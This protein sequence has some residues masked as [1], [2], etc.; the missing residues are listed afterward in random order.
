[1][2]HVFLIKAVC[3]PGWIHMFGR[4]SFARKQPICCDVSDVATTTGTNLGDRVT[5][6]GFCWFGIADFPAFCSCGEKNVLSRSAFL[7]PKSGDDKNNVTK[8]S[9]PLVSQRRLRV[10]LMEG[11]KWHLWRCF[12][13]MSASGRRNVQHTHTHTHAEAWVYLRLN[14]GHRRFVIGVSQWSIAFFLFPFSMF[15]SL[16]LSPDIIGTLQLLPIQVVG[17]VWV[18]VIYILILIPASPFPTVSFKSSPSSHLPISLQMFHT[19]EQPAIWL[20]FWSV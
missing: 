18:R 9:D 8:W 5:S 3:G 17:F 14:C 13:A 19:C 6:C 10:S 16:N 2:Q 15:T 12:T 4:F 1:M 11:A 20:P 7:A